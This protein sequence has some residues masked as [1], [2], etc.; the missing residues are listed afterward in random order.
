MYSLFFI[1]KR[2]FFLQMTT[3]RSIKKCE[4]NQ[5]IQLWKCAFEPKAD[6]YFERYF[7]N[8]ASPDYKEGDCLGAWIDDN[9]LASVVYIRRMILKST[10][11]KRM[12]LCGVISNVSTLN[13]YRNM[14]LSRELLKRSIE[15]MKDENF[16]FS[17]LGTGRSGHYS[18]LGWK[19]VPIQT[20]YLI[21]N[22][23]DCLI[24]SDDE[25]I[26]WTPASS[27]TSYEK[28]FEIYQSNPRSYELSRCHASIFEHWLGWHW[29]QNSSYIGLLSNNQGYIIISQPDGKHGH[30]NICE[31]RT[32][33]IENEMKLLSIARQHIFERFHRKKFII[34]TIP[35]FTDFDELK[36]KYK[37]SEQN[38]DVMFRNIQLAEN[39]FDDIQTSFQHSHCRS[40][41]WPEEYF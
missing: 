8:L 7:S 12:Y 20:E 25:D 21:E 2:A 22:D 4:E 6:G 9:I 15:K 1:K 41:I 28:L 30:L 29:K 10:N 38:E 18:P 40:T 23:D 3:L 27:F 11:D 26:I 33:S 31:W 14:G 13:E 39:V 16:D 24:S 17:I 35:Q 5:V 32:N 37:S 34:H 19:T 36:W